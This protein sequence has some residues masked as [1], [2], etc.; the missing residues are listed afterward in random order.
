M[1]DGCSDCGAPAVAARR[2][3]GA[4][5]DAPLQAAA[6]RPSTHHSTLLL[7]RSSPQG[8]MPFKLSVRCNLKL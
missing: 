4:S 2:V 6:L 3:L 1:A 7:A 5:L 8:I